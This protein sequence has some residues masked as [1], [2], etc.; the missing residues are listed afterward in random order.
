MKKQWKRKPRARK[1]QVNVNRAL[2]PFAQ[3]YITKMKY[4]Q[5][6][7]LSS[8]NFIQQFNLNSLWDPDRTGLGHQP[9]GFDELAALYRRYRVINCSYAVN[10]ASGSAI[11]LVAHPTNATP[12]VLSISDVC[13]RPRAKWVIQHPGGSTATLKG[14]CYLPSLEGRTKAQYMADDRYQAEVTTSPL[15]LALLSIYGKALDDGSVDIACVITLNFT[16]EFFDIK[17]LGQS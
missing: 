9:H 15:E 14:N 1:A 17:A 2:T 3:R 11:R 4:S 5:T 10:A 16:V 8:L 12:S 6:F 7:T 13:E